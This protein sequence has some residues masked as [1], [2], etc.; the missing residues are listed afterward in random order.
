MADRASI[1]MDRATPARQHRP[2]QPPAALGS[3]AHPARDGGEQHSAFPPGL[4]ELIAVA[5]RELAIHVSSA[6]SCAVC[7][8]AFPCQRAQLAEFSLGSLIPAGPARQQH[9]WELPGKPD[10]VR[11]ARRLLASALGDWPRAG[12]AVLV[13]SELAANAVRHSRSGEPG[14]TFTIRAEIAPG[15]RVLLEVRDQGGPWRPRDGSDQGGRGLRIVDK[16]TAAMR[17]DGNPASGWTV[18]AVLTA[19]AEAPAGS[20][21]P[22]PLSDT[23]EPSSQARIRL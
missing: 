17:I 10:Q 16:L 7:K 14:G 15:S 21:A 3:P 20:P 8:T 1:I 11:R 6:G 13:L 5:C 18:T 19:Q 2:T 12:D 9:R 23:G 22:G 4:S